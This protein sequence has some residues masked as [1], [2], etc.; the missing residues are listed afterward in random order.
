MKIV[1][2][3]GKCFLKCKG[4]QISRRVTAELEELNTISLSIPTIQRAIKSRNLRHQ[5]VVDTVTKTNIRTLKKYFRE[6]SD[7]KMYEEV[8]GLA[9]RKIVVYFSDK[10]YASPSTPGDFRL[11]MRFNLR[12]HSMAERLSQIKRI[13]NCMDYFQVTNEPRNI[14]PQYFKCKI[15]VMRL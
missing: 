1:V 3:V 9:F 12:D 5:F 14:S 6:Q 15:H 4:D 13:L 8:H 11:S 7:P 2:R 10:K